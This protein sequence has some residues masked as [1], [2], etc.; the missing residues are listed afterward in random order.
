MR[1]HSVS[2]QGMYSLPQ[3][4][5]SSSSG[6]SPYESSISPRS[7]VP[8]GSPGGL[9]GHSQE[10]YSTSSNTGQ[11]D[12]RH[13]VS[14]PVSYAPQRDSSVRGDEPDYR[15]SYTS[16]MNRN[17]I[18]TS[19]T[20]DYQMQRSRHSVLDGRYS[21]MDGR[22]SHGQPLRQMTSHASPVTH[23]QTNVS[24]APSTPTKY[25]QTP[26]SYSSQQQT[27]SHE[28]GGYSS[29]GYSSYTFQHT[30]SSDRS[31]MYPASPSA[32]TTRL[33]AES[34]RYDLRPSEIPRQSEARPAPPPPLL[35]LQTDVRATPTPPAAPLSENKN[36]LNTS[37]PVDAETVKAPQPQET[38][39]VVSSM[40]SPAK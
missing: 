9:R 4:P 25:P 8:Q 35:D 13:Y 33:V 19:L 36:S 29:S 37:R 21:E 5:V 15:Q 14:R 6:Y 17:S 3:R 16:S 26:P 32:S 40:P 27:H 18:Q 11:I 23:H 24:H 7:V 39:T 10:S 1:P 34:S 20:S 30:P 28:G 12:P 2:G 31:K 38:T 22:D